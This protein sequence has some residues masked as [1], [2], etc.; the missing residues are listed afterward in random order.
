ML[1][2]KVLGMGVAVKVSGEDGY[3]DFLFFLLVQVFGSHQ[4]DAARQLLPMQDCNTQHLPERLHA[5]QQ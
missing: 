5:C 4:N 1:I 2:D 3:S